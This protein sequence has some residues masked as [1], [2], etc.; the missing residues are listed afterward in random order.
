MVTT[1][2]GYD[3]EAVRARLPALQ[4]LTYLNTGTE[5]LLA[6]PVLAAYL[7][8]VAAHDR[9]GHVGIARAAAESEAGR[10][11]LAALLHAEA[12]EI[13]WTHNATD[14]VNL[15]VQS[16][17]WPMDG[18][19]EVVIS[20]EEHP[21]IIMPWYTLAARGGPRVRQFAISPE[22]DETL[23]NFAAA[24]SART[25]AI[26][27]SH[28]SCETGV[29]LPIADICRMAK[30]RGAWAFVDGAQSVGQFDLAPRDLGADVL[31]GNGHKW[32][33]GPK[34]T[35][36][37]W[38]AR[39]RL[40]DLTPTFVG[41]GTYAREGLRDAFVDNATPE[42]T[43]MDS[44][45]RFEYG[46]RNFGPYAGLDA[47]LR[48]RESLGAAAI[49]AHQAALVA[50]LK[51]DLMTIPGVTVHTPALWERSCGIVTFSL[52][53]WEG[54]ALSR[55]LW[56]EHHLIQRRVERPSAVRVSVS[57]FTSADDCAR[58]CDRLEAIGPRRE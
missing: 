28:V 3:L 18:T 53:G 43:L 35:G 54:A 36:F 55:T 45:R 2:T 34:G 41:S 57:Y 13:A 51:R 29:R 38:V 10:E 44:A 42:M 37:L 56:D 46:T 24:L 58:L 19:A 39:E 32:L 25:V 6:E 8:A 9:Y 5:G 48:Y 17:R 31:T 21:A 14:G 33:C 50:R 15:F 4:E 7:E 52:A 27:V 47:A 1:A 49:E 11:R 12:D 30:E 22:P 26:A 23:A 20:N 40:P 16:A